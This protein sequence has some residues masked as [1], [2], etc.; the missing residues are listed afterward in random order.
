MG[1][2]LEGQVYLGLDGGHEFIGVVGGEQATHVLDADTVRAHVS[3][4]TRLAQKVVE[5]VDV[6]AHP[7]ALADGVADGELKMLSRV[8]DSGGRAFQVGFVVEGVEDAED[9][10]AILG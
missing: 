1:V 2:E 5:I 4:A 6:A 10:N 8:L 9:V 7:A 3:E